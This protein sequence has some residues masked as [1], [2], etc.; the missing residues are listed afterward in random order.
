MPLEVHSTNRLHQQCV[1]GL[2]Y[3]GISAT[4]E[5]LMGM[6]PVG[7]MATQTGKTINNKIAH[8][9]IH[10]FRTITN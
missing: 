9:F 7:G 1:L 3:S 10:A 8:N 5:R 6:V 4:G 2:E